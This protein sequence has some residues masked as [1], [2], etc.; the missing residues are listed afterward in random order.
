MP[1][2]DHDDDALRFFNSLSGRLVIELSEPPQPVSPGMLNLA[3]PP[4]A[5]LRSL[6]LVMQVLVDVESAELRDLT[7]SEWNRVVLRSP[8]IRMRGEE[9]SVVEHRAVEGTAFTVRDLA[10]AIAETERQTRGQ[11]EW[12]G[13]IDV[14]HIY[15]EGIELEEDGV[16]FISWGS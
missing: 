9:E 16:W 15:F 8:V 14:H 3:S 4:T 5:R 12:L 6:S 10:A 7:D 1:E 11:T 2:A 13:G